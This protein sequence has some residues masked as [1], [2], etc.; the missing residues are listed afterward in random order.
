M[1]STE[2]KKHHYIS[3]FLLKNFSHSEN[4]NVFVLDKKNGKI[5]KSSLLDTGSENFFYKYT[6]SKSDINTEAKLAKLES[7]CAPIVNEVIRRESIEAISLKE[8]TLLCLFASVQHLRTNK[9]RE[10]IEQLNRFMSES[11]KS[12]GI[13]PNKDVENF[14]ELSEE[15][16]K[17]ASIS[18]LHSLGAE[19]AQYF[20]DKEIRLVKA[21]DEVEFYISD[22][23]ITLYN[24][25]PRA[26]RG[27]LGLGLRGIEIQF[28]LSP[29]LCMVFFC[30]KTVMKLRLAV[31]HCK[32]MKQLGIAVPLETSDPEKYLNELD[33]KLTKV[34]KPENVEFNNWLQVSQSSRFIYCHN[35][36]FDL[37]V[38]VLRKSPELNNPRWFNN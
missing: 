25:F 13:D 15:E 22:H 31:S 37:A 5:Y 20:V 28:P 36:D 34:L 21:P 4:K 3:Q 7:I 26:G 35:G 11:F 33:A 38:D 24:Y 10:E 8:R 30:S 16:I 1:S 23:P 29:K 2:P 27:N 9:Q 17:N 19:L 6:A 14:K 18:N 32:T 12:R